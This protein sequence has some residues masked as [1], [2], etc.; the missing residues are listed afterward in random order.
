MST[1]LTW[2]TPTHKMRDPHHP[3]RGG[4]IP[5]IKDNKKLKSTKKPEL[6]ARP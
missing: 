6:T 1:S 3:Q 2:N 5:S 4:F